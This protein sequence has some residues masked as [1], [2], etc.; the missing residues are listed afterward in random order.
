MGKRSVVLGVSQLGGYAMILG[1]DWR[2]QF[3]LMIFDFFHA[4][5]EF[6]YG[7]SHII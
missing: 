3:S 1:V 2:K 7:D 5:V 4:T 6:H